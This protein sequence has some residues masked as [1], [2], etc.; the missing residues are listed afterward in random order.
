MSTSDLKHWPIFS[1]IDQKFISQI[2]MVVVYGNLG[3][4]SLM[5]T[6]DG[7][8]YAIG[9]NTSRCLGTGDSLSSLHPRKVEALCGKGPIK[10]FAFGIGPHVLALMVNGEVYSWGFNAYCQLGNG[11]T[12]EGLTPSLITTNLSG[13]IV[14]DIACGSHHSLALTDKGELY[15]WGYN[16]YGQVGSGLNS[17]QSTPRKINS[18]LSERKIVSIAC[19]Q[20][21][22]MAVTENGEV[23]GWGGNAAGQIGNGTFTNQLTPCKVIGLMGVVIEKI[24]CG[25]SH[26]L[27][28]SDGGV[29]YGWGSNTY[30][31]LGFDNKTNICTPTK[32]S[33]SKMGMVSDIAASHCNHISAAVGAGGKI[34]MWGQCLG[35]SIT[36]PTLTSLSHLHNVLACY[37]SCSVMHCPLILHAEEE[38]SVMDC[39]R[40]AFNDPALSDLVFEVR[41]EPIYVHKAVL[42]IRCQYFRTMFQEH[43]TE[44]SERIIKHDDYSYE[45]YKAFLK[46]LYTDKVDLS[47]ENAL[48]LL[49]LANAYIEPQLKRRCVEVI[50]QGITIS[51]VALLYSTAIES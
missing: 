32:L 25:Y 28:L 50:K 40:E 2:H 8:V 41:G 46:Y 4:E 15:A 45:V 33:A 23:Y 11:T 12:N 36:E 51:N 49:N 31:E 7:T 10:T 18:N 9:N 29:I 21:S 44:N 26:T 24:V 19:G 34:F 5:V 43:W 14:V 3:N 35:I 27:A 22:C 16:N 38:I 1:L 37:A 30:G 39:L 20:L 42:K 13:K 47:P 17:N 48:E 6:K